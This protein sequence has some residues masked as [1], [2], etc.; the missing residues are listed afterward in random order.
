MYKLHQ[1][2]DEVESAAE[3][4]ADTANICLE[5]VQVRFDES[6][7]ITPVIREQPAFPQDGGDSLHFWVVCLSLSLRCTKLGTFFLLSRETEFGLVRPLS[8]DAI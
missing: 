5:S 4:V 8:L 1:A 2:A 6:L 3:I 7:R